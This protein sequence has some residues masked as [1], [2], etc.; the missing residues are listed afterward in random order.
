V[1]GQLDPERPVRVAVVDDHELF[2]TS[3]GMFLDA[4]QGIEFVGSAGDGPAGIDLAVA[5]G[6]DVVLMDLGLPVMDG[7]EATRRLLAIRPDA[8]VI[9]ITG[10]TGDE[11]RRE[12]AVHAGAV[13]FLTKGL[14][15]EEVREAIF[16]AAAAAEQA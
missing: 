9:V 8:K 13:D 5:S 10:R 11:G 12:E 15:H 6:A 14:V 1:V 16:R 7:F 3:M 2:A 4:T